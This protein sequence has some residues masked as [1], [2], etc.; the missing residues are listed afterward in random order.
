M[1]LTLEAEQMLT[2]VNLVK[3][4]KTH[5]G[6][7]TTLARRCHAFVKQNFPDSAIVR[8][9]DVAKAL[10]PFIEVDADLIHYLNSKRLSQKYWFRH[11]SDL[12]LDRTWKQIK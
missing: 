12:I 2:S 5:V 10:L 7:W 6:K 3:F 8:P 9:D 4:F 1:S 11:F